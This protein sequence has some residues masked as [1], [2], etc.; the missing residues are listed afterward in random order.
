MGA[1]IQIAILA[2]AA[3]AKAELASLADSAE[4][5][6]GRVKAGLGKIGEFAK[7]GA[8][9]AGLA[10][11]A[12]LVGGITEALNQSDVS[13]KLGAQLGLTKQESA[14]VGKAAGRI[15]ADNYGESF[16]QVNEAIKGVYQNIGKLAEPALKDVT[17]QVLTVAN[18][19]DQ[20]L[21]GTTAAVGQLMKTGLA[22][23]ATEALDTIT[24]GLQSGADK[25]GDLLDTFNEYGTQ[26]RKFGLDG[27][28]ATGLLSQGLKAG[29]RD[30]DVVADAIKE[31]SIRAV[32]GSK[33]TEQGFTSLGLAGKQ[34][35]D[36][37]AAGG[38]KASAALDTT[39][40][41]LRAI[42]DP[43]ERSRIAVQLF[44]TQAED[45]GDALFAL[46][47]ST[48]VTGLGEVAGAAK[49]AGDAMGETP[50]AK[51]EKF[52]RT[53]TQGFVEGLGGLIG[54]FESLGQLVGPIWDGLSAKAKPFVDML[55][56]KLMPKINELWNVIQTQVVPA[57]KD[58][59][60]ALAPLYAWLAE[61]L[62]PIV[63]K[64][65]GSIVDIIKGAL[66][67]ITGV[68]NVFV[69]ILTGDWSKAW[70]GIKQI[71][72]GAW[73][74]IKAVMS[75]AW[76]VVKGLFTTGVSGIVA[77]A[78]T[79]GSRIMSA[80][81]SLGGLLLGWGNAA[82]QKAKS[83]FTSGVSSAVST[84]KE[85]PGK[86]KAAL[87][88]L[89]SY[90]YSAGQDM[91]RGLVNGIKA[92]AGQAVS[93]AK[94]VVGD[95]VSGAKRL[96][97]IASPS[98]VFT[99]IGKQT[100]AGFVLGL[101]ST[102][103]AAQKATKGFVKISELKAYAKSIGATFSA[104]EDGSAAIYKGKT[105]IGDT[106]R[107]LSNGTA[108]TQTRAGF[109]DSKYQDAWEAKMLRSSA[110][111]NVA[112]PVGGSTAAAPAV[113]ELRSSGSRL[114]DLLLELLRGAI[115]ARGGNVQKVLGR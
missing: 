53:L 113:I 7:A 103:N 4:K 107:W 112:R 12:A 40:D 66:Q 98:K 70:E 64:V 10:T 77:I 42:K 50:A 34:M 72:S 115:S 23:N 74:V 51:I 5:A 1:T 33:T 8:V 19:F 59:A 52:K 94:G 56:Q 105:K 90:L 62:F 99:E 44:G 108:T 45:L 79:I 97:G 101:Q 100:G 88:N 67:V 81:S 27:K 58:W 96:L 13:A 104:W 26:F 55:A 76:A 89:G 39:L 48:A 85:L 18:T 43:V 57:M 73:T 11:G 30:A 91:I 41:R 24:V 2:Q 28:T 68:I 9:G 106:Y 83:A 61:K 95:A 114:D 111:I 102:A 109:T 69:G 84:A 29:A 3:K 15:Y 78:S 46:D 86:V 110:S 82:W 17:S 31:F 92:M 37:I 47:P 63:V 65:F 60:E 54:K 80:I 38:P 32:D 36:D 21:G 16:G 25:A 49:R 6:G 20:D 93:A 35:A 87:G 22:A 75:A 71:L 14:T